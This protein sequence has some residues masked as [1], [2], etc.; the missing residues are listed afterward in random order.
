MKEF[1]DPTRTP[2]TYRNLRRFSK[3]CGAVVIII[4]F[5]VLVGWI[6]DITLLKGLRSDTVPMNPVVAIATIASGVA[7]WLKQED[8]CGKYDKKADL[9]AYFIILVGV[10]KI[11]SVVSHLRIPYDEVL[12]HEKL[13]LPE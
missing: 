2:S 5:L 6:F 13:W 3:I 7:L 11:I 1:K 4:G 12:F 10:L 8:L 9:L